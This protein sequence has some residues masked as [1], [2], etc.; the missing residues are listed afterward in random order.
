MASRTAFA[1]SV[2]RSIKDLLSIALTFTV[3]CGEYAACCGAAAGVAA[4]TVV[5]VPCWLPR[6]TASIPTDGGGV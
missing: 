4:G 5:A 6:R 1:M 3:I 2:L